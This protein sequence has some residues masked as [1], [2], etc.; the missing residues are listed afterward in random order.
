M[1]NFVAVDFETSKGKNPCSIG[2]VEF[3]DYKVVNQYYSLIRPKELTFNKINQGIHGI[4]VD[5]V[6]N[7]REFPLVWAEI[8][9]IIS[10]K[11]LVSHNFSFDLSVL[12]YALD[13]YSLPKIDLEF[14]CTLS[15]S[16]QALRLRNYKLSTVAGFFDIKQED[17]HNALEDAYVC[18]R[19]YIEL[20]S[21]D[22]DYSKPYRVPNVKKLEVLNEK[23]YDARLILKKESS[24]LNNMRIVISGIFRKF[25]RNEV[26]NI[27][28]NNGGKVS[29]SISKKTTYVVAGDNMGPSKKTKAESLGVEI[30]SEDDFIKMIS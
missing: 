26:K 21:L 6:V 17:Y 11:K 29:S 22:I 5:D 25:S 8:Y 4:T 20:C 1:E 24:K 16:R 2:L 10:G 3:K 12:E 23:Y 18:G 14:S 27:I 15:M 9:P 13:L 28:S 7:E 19:V 30:I